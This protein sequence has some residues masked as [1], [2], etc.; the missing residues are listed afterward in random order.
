MSSLQASTWLPEVGPAST[1]F[2]DQ[3]SYLDEMG[4][5]NLVDDSRRIL[6]RCSNP[7]DATGSKTV[8]VV[9]EV[10]SGKT[11][12]FTTVMSVARENGFQIVILLAGTKKNL[13][14]QTHDRLVKDLG[15]EDASSGRQWRV[16]KNPK[17]SAKP[18]LLSALD[19]WSDVRVPV[20][21]RESLVLVV[22]KTEAGLNHATNLISTVQAE[23]GGPIP[24]LVIDDEADQASLNVS[25]DPDEKSSTY[26]AVSRLRESLL[27]HSYV[28][29]TATSQALLLLDLVDHLSP[30]SVVVLKAA[31]TYVGG[32]ILFEDRSS[33]FFR[34][35]PLE[36]IETA[37]DPAVTDAAPI[38][39]QSS[40]AYFLVALCVAQQ[41]VN[42]VPFSMLIHPASRKD[43][44]ARY[45]VWVSAILKR[46]SMLLD[47]DDETSYAALLS[48]DFQPAID[49]L[50]RTCDLAS[51][52][53]DLSPD[54]VSHHIVSLIRYWI[55]LV[56]VRVV[57][58]E[59]KDNEIGPQDW[60]KFPGWIV[61]GGAKLERGFTIENLAVTYMPR[62]SGIGAADTVQQR[63][64]FF[65][66]KRAYEDLLRGWLNPDTR[67]AF[68]SIIEFEEGV[69]Q[70]LLRMDEL[71]TP[72][73]DWRREF[74][75][76]A[77]M[78]A[79]RRA[80]ISL[81]HQS[82]DLGPGFRF[83]QE[84]LFWDPL[85][86]MHGDI[87]ERL[88][89]YQLLKEPVILDTRRTQHR[90][91]RCNISIKDLVELIFWWPMTPEDKS[92][93]DHLLVALKYY[94]DS[95]PDVDAHL[96]F[97][98]DLQVRRRKRAQSRVEIEYD[99]KFWRTINLHQGPDPRGEGY[100]GDKAM[101]TSDAVSVQVHNIVPRNDNDEY[102][103]VLALA[104]A[105]P[106]GF[107][108][109]VLVQK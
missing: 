61:I 40:L 57:N 2:L 25:Q 34:E 97:M 7:R 76:G 83:K 21:F 27:N 67:E 41:R 14:N 32:K 91:S 106:Q 33:R 51:V 99:R 80:V 102:G 8:L 84:H 82:I 36:E 86:T 45:R 5:Q 29:Y 79:T 31:S 107:D 1:R 71:G 70:E 96:Y 47:L 44:H 46:W 53:P 62:G 30:D 43:V 77:G 90:N 28:M 24:I 42:P 13:L 15:V 23:R 6:G 60:K 10:Q 89:R 20:Q 63:G 35:I 109:T 92:R 105:W 52:F 101:R 37:T 3:V 18:Q 54:Q 88:K 103:P 98:D 17:I 78:V 100:L 72:L 94:G 58:S 4:R 93:V 22:L 108:R 26:R 87:L 12:S 104:I 38:S 74:I 49:E 73:K 66:H 64:R 50:R 19:T 85:R 11:L 81:S 95:Q 69:R 9:G 75:L 65:G 16:I 48:A 39:L 68:H 59:K 55:N 56:E